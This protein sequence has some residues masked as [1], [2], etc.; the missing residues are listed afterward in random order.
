MFECYFFKVSYFNYLTSFYP[1]LLT[2]ISNFNFKISNPLIFQ[3]SIPYFFNKFVIKNFQSMWQNFNSFFY[4]FSKNFE[5]MQKFFSTILHT[6]KF[7]SSINQKFRINVICRGFFLFSSFFL[8]EFTDLHSV[9]ILLEVSLPFGVSK[10]KAEASWKVGGP[11][12]LRLQS[13]NE[14]VISTLASNFP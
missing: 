11:L 1:S 14:S 10:F 4:R 13:G 3:N 7:F 9:E 2:F 8:L 12:S 5:S 6:V